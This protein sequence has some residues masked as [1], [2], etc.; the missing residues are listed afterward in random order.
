MNTA[1]EW[2]LLSS[3]QRLTTLVEQTEWLLFRA[4]SLG[5]SVDRRSTHAL[6][7][8]RRVLAGNFKK[9]ETKKA[10]G[11]AFDAFQE[12]GGL[13]IL[14]SSLNRCAV[15]YMCWAVVTNAY[16]K[17]NNN[18]KMSEILDKLENIEEIYLYHDGDLRNQSPLAR[19][20]VSHDIET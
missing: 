8:A 11:A 16:W 12:G 1:G 13:A 5:V 10:K 20:L 15:A 6:V 17:A 3:N 18:K 2:N 4:I 9:E 7:E 19:R 14:G